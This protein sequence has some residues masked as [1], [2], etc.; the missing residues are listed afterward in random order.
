MGFHNSFASRHP[1]QGVVVNLL[2]FAAAVLLFFGLV[3]PI[4]TLEKFY[5]FSNTVSLWSAL[6]TLAAEAEWGLFVL[7]GSF[8][9][10]FPVLKLVMLLLIWNLEDAKG[11]RHRRHLRWLETYSKWSMLD[12]FV[13][14][15]LVVSIKLGAMLQAKVEFGIYAFAASVVL[16]M[17][18]SN[19]I[20]THART[21]G[22]AASKI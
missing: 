5:F 2:L 3:N 18:L 6:G 13:V 21:S 8:S 19:W 11:E 4:L 15:L 7:V 1:L 10:L 22:Q 16:T 12:V 20:G 14:A 17:L 9:V